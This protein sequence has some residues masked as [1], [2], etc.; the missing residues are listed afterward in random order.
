MQTNYGNITL[1]LYPDKAPQTVA[2]FLRYVDSG[3]YENTIFHR[4]IPGF[5]IQGGGFDLDYRQ[6]ETLKPVANE[7]G[8]SLENLRGTIAMARTQDPHSATAQ[9]F[10]NVANND[11]LNYRS[12]DPQ[13]WG[14]C[15]F[16]RVIEGMGVADEIAKVPTGPG[17]PFPTDAPQGLV[18]IDG[19][20]RESVKS[21]KSL[22]QPKT[23]PAPEQPTP[24]SPQQPATT[25][26]ESS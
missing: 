15:V 18:V 2:N 14:Y 24:T 5:M 22:V 8:N 6:K 23:V 26:K 21:Q 11:F 7:A 12:P 20:K 3:F 9:F 10:I 16:G 4:V 1:E 17:G 13:G 25:A 19:I